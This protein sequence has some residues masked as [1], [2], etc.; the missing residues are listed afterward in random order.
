M[1][2][3]IRCPRACAA[4]CCWTSSDTTRIRPGLIPRRR[5]LC[6]MSW[7]HTW[8]AVVLAILSK[9]YGGFLWLFI[10]ILKRTPIMRSS[11]LSIRC[12]RLYSSDLRH[13][14]K[15]A[16]FSVFQLSICNEPAPKTCLHALR[17]LGIF[18]FCSAYFGSHFK[19]KLIMLRNNA[20]K[21]CMVN[22]YCLKNE[23]RLI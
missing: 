6:S 21:I 20:R 12:A 8:R 4:R 16:I 22:S 17:R 18:F 1:T 5:I 11:M 23:T 14:Q 2:N 9:R 3:S 10:C 7:R 15:A 13:N 19:L